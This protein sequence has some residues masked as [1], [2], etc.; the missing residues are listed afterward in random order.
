M[1]DTPLQ[2]AL[3]QLKRDSANDELSVTSKGLEALQKLGTWTL[4]EARKALSLALRE[5]PRLVSTGEVSFAAV[6]ERVQHVLSREMLDALVLYVRGKLVEAG[7]CEEEI[8]GLRLYTGPLFV[9]TNRVLRSASRSKEDNNYG[10]VIHAIVSGISKLAKV[11]GIPEGRMVY[12]GVGGMRLPKRFYEEDET[13]ARGG[14][15]RAFR[16]TTTA[17]EVAINY[18]CACG[19]EMATLFCIQVDAVNKG[20]CISHVS[21]FPEEEEVLMPPGSYL[22]VVGEPK[23]EYLDVSRPPVLMFVLQISCPQ[24]TT[25]E[26]YRTSRKNNLLAM[27][28]YAQLEI[29]RDLGALSRDDRV[30]QR[31][32]VDVSC[33]KDWH[34]HILHSED[35][36]VVGDH[37][38]EPS[39]HNSGMIPEIMNECRRWVEQAIESR[40]PAAFNDDVLYQR[41]VKEACDLKRLAVG[42]VEAWLND[43]CVLAL[44]MRSIPL[45]AA[46]RHACGM[47]RRELEE[48]KADARAGRP[49]CT[50][51]RCREAALRLCRQYGLVVLSAVENIDEGNRET[52]LMR[53]AALGAT[54][55]ARLLVDAGAEPD[56]TDIEGQTALMY[57]AS[58]GQTETVLA[59][60]KECGSNVESADTKTGKT[61]ALWAAK[62]GHTA[63]VVA[64]V[65][66]CGA[67]L[68]R[69]DRWGTSAV[70][71]AALGGH[72]TTLVAL[73]KECGADANTTNN[74]GRNAVM[75]AAFG[76]H[77]ATI[78]ALV[79]EFGV[80]ANAVS[81]G[82][83]TA[84]MGA[85]QTGC[86]AAVVALVNGCG[87]D[88][89]AVD[90]DGM[91]ALML[92]AAGG[93]TA[94]VVALVN[95][96]GAVANIADN[97]GMTAV[98]LAAKEGHTT[99][100]VALVNE[101]GA[102]ANVADDTG[103]TAVMLAATCEPLTCNGAD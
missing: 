87:A 10:N 76:G 47:L 49:D 74:N 31:A 14:V 3:K 97:T 8:I 45:R 41:Q 58:T 100:V 75:L 17:R 82:G 7:L 57:A 54:A 23:V 27:A 26:M 101:C 40:E 93:H 66:E 1:F 59:L 79:K 48:A 46:D 33:A 72:T 55:A 92:A 88:A 38:R 96:C 5:A 89:N 99:T 91:T 43:P 2:R 37:T 103:M 15:E 95:E 102:D 4:K 39:L 71:L 61:A 69:T 60:V 34:K 50:G 98:M 51:S 24:T 18:A 30:V 65:K 56:A 20:A 35:N 29:L 73:V 80:N 94:T 77:T 36:L 81:I 64:L 12:C 44:H 28:R 32:K 68:C 22:E 63:T 6:A 83:R 13:G 9:K 19:R 25:I 52:M 21:Q 85:A 42:K 11:S 62:A 67:D 78:V 70:M 16:S 86:S 84:V 53:Q 90:N